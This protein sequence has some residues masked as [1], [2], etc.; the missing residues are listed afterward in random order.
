MLSLLEGWTV[1]PS[2][3]TS[4]KTNEKP[5]VIQTRRQELTDDVEEEGREGYR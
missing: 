4:G 1:N 3:S 2:H 5:S